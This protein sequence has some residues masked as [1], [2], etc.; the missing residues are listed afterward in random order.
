LASFFIRC[1]EAANPQI[2]AGLLKSLPARSL[3]SLCR[4]FSYL[5]QLN[6]NVFQTFGQLLIPAI[7]LLF[8]NL[9]FR[10]KMTF[11]QFFQFIRG[12]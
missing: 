12:F 7:L 5:L 3:Y 1:N 8:Q 6:A 11:R 4:C 2:F 10:G 9:N